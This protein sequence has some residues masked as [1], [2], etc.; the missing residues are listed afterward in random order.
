[1]ISQRTHRAGSALRHRGAFCASPDR[2]KGLPGGR[3]LDSACAAP[4]AGSLPGAKTSS[5]GLRLSLC[6]TACVSGIG[7]PSS[8]YALPAAWAGVRPLGWSTIAVRCSREEPSS[9]GTQ[10]WSAAAWS[11][12]TAHTLCVCRRSSWWGSVCVAVLAACGSW[13]RSETRGRVCLRPEH[14]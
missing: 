6:A 1:M 5:A 11:K 13:E 12:V 2:V 4:L 3:R 9:E 7:A 8:C 14:A 10:T